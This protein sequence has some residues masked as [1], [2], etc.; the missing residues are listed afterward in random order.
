MKGGLFLL[1]EESRTR[2]EARTVLVQYTPSQEAQCQLQFTPLERLQRALVA[3]RW[4]TSWY[5]TK[6]TVAYT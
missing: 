1:E 3:A 5:S 6:G 2:G 4:S